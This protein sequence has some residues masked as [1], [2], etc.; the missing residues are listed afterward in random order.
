LCG[1]QNA[2]LRGKIHFFKEL[3]LFFGR[4]DDMGR[5]ASENFFVAPPLTLYVQD[6]RCVK[7]L[8]YHA[9]ASIQALEITPLDI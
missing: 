8:L 9:A 1:S 4:G 2:T 3:L 6:R 7:A 5:F